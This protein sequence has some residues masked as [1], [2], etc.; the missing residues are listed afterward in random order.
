MSI[1]IRPESTA[2]E[3]AIRQV[4]RLA[5]DQDEEARLV[6]AL[7]EGGFVRVSLVAEQEGRVV[8]HIL[9]SDLPIITGT[10]TVPA[11][12]LAPMA[13]LPEFQN[14][15]IGSTLVRRGLEACRQ[16]GHRVVVVLGHTH[17]YPRF[18]FSPKLAADLESPFS[19]G[20][21]FMA[22]ELAL[23]RW[24]GVKG[25]VQYAPPFEGVPQVRPVRADD[26]AE[27]LRMR[28]LLWPDGAGDAHA[29]EVAA[30]FGS[31]SFP[32]SGPFLAVAVFVAVRPSG[33]LCGFL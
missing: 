5:F 26:Q 21:S 28:R 8:G 14:Q 15:G 2:D 30:F 31:Q 10:G 13:V 29:Q 33:G 22:V 32:W 24:T 18:G 6:D 1:I 11:L 27:W 19:G 9:F 12:A 17:F 25:R 7:R 3:D 23:G 20:D 4:N 16:Q